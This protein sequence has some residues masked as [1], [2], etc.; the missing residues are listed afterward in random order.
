M[1]ASH[2]HS[3]LGHR[4]LSLV[5]ALVFTTL[6]AA[7]HAQVATPTVTDPRLVVRPVV[8]GLELPT[9]LAFLGADDFLILEKNSGRVVRVTGGVQQGA[10]LDLAVNNASER[11]LLGIA[12]HPDF[13]NNG[14][15]Y[16]FWSCRT[17][18]PSADPFVPDETTCAATPALGEDTSVISA[19]PLLGNRVDRFHWDGAALSFDRNLVTLRAFQNDAA[20][21]PPNQGDETQPPRANHDGGILRFGPDGKLYVLF[22]DVGRRG[23]LQNLPSGPTTTGLGDVVADDQFGGPEPDDAHLAGVILRLNDDGSTPTDNPFYAYGTGLGTEVGSNLAMVYSYGIRNSFGMAFDPV[24]GDLWVQE[25][26]EDAFDEINRVTAGMN[27]GWIQFA[28]PASRVAQFREIET[29][30]LHHEDFPNLQQLRWGPERIATTEADAKAR[31][32]VLPGSTYRDPEFSWKYVMAPAGI[33]FVEGRAL[34]PRYEGDLLLGMSVPDPVGGPL[35][36]FQL[37]K[38]Q[39]TL[40]LGDSR[41]ADRVADNLEPHE[42]TE[43]ES[44][45]LGSGFGIVTDIATAPDKSGVFVVSLDHGTVWEIAQAPRGRPADTASGAKGLRLATSNDGRTTIAGPHGPGAAVARIDFELDQDVT[46]DA[47]VYDVQGRLVRGLARRQ[48]FA[49]GTGS[50]TWDGRTEAGAV[51]SPGA[52]FVRL[53]AGTEQVV[54]RLLWL[55]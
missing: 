27:S 12:L 5:A 21:T 4:T 46:L 37:K 51:A 45:V 16:L 17:A 10:V 55:R 29:T 7:A 28:G 53:N 22:G 6:A 19:T 43:S 48:P 8:S 44:L 3:A 13:A 52:Y 50:V 42:L 25:N 34:G 40:A 11:G 14:W 23:Q 26:G 2:P 36:R 35:M 47:G 18:G 9:T 41:L 30:S 24:G 39:R 33:G 49:A 32:F 15:V 1:P 20:P 38:H 31:L 54:A